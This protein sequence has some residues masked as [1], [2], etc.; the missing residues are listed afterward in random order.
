MTTIGDVRRYLK[1]DE[2]H[3]LIPVIS[4]PYSEGQYKNA[5]AA[6]LRRIAQDHGLSFKVSQIVALDDKTD[7]S[8]EAEQLFTRLKGVV[9]RL[10]DSI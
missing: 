8:P 5:L 2:T 7:L 4:N 6:L 9:E 10:V 1:E 3:L